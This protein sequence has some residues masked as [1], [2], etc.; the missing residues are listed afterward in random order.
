M[1]VSVVVNMQGVKNALDQM[2]DDL[3]NIDPLLEEIGQYMVNSTRHRI[4]RSKRAPDGTRWAPNAESTIERKGHGSVLFETG[5]LAQGIHVSELDG[6]SVT[7]AASDDTPYAE[8]M[9]D[10]FYNKRTKTSVP[11]RPFFGPLTDANKKA[12]ATRVN[13]YLNRMNRGGR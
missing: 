7:I 13:R 12:I 9:Q 10:G 5:A 3:E 8:Y 6:D 1:T 4:L 2:I 11:A